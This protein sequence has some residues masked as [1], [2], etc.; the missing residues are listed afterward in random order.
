MVFNRLSVRICSL[1]CITT[2]RP[3][4][5][6]SSP[7]HQNASSRHNI[8]YPCY[9]YLSHHSQTCHGSWLEIAHDAHG[10]PR[11]APRLAT[12]EPEP[13]DTELLPWHRLWLVVRAFTKILR[14][15]AD[16]CGRHIFNLVCAACK[17]RLC[18]C[19]VRQ[20]P[21]VAGHKPFGPCVAPGMLRGHHRSRQQ[22]PR[23][24]QWG[25]CLTMHCI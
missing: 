9:F 14:I 4:L 2:R 20:R 8:A 7:A 25:M 22:Q 23:V 19:F 6:V 15:A 13:F 12:K 11:P 5:H 24:R 10:V 21:I 18:V 17:A 1:L 16:A 3:P